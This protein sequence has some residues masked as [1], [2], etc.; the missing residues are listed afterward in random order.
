[1]QHSNA[2]R[3]R[4]FPRLPAIELGDTGALVEERLPVL[5]R[6]AVSAWPQQRRQSPPCGAFS[7]S[8]TAGRRGARAS[9]SRSSPSMSSSMPLRLPPV[10]GPRPRSH[11]APSSPAVQFF[12]SQIGAFVLRPHRPQPGLGSQRASAGPVITPELLSAGLSSDDVR[13]L[14]AAGGIGGHRGHRSQQAAV[15]RSY[16]PYGPDAFALA[17]R[18]RVRMSPPPSVRGGL[19]ASGRNPQ[20]SCQQASQASKPRTAVRDSADQRPASR[21]H[22]ACWRQRDCRRA[23]PTKC[24]RVLRPLAGDRRAALASLTRS[25]GSQQPRVSSGS[26]TQRDHCSKE[27]SGSPVLRS[28][29]TTAPAPDRQRRR[30]QLHP[31]VP[32][33][34]ADVGG[35]RPRLRVFSARIEVHRDEPPSKVFRDRQAIAGEDYEGRGVQGQHLRPAKHPNA[36]RP[37]GDRARKQV[38]PEGGVVQIVEK[39]G[40]AA[41]D[42]LRDDALLQLFRRRRPP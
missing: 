29:A 24:G 35:E 17:C 3:F 13:L 23:F 19:T 11:A 34:I 32:D 12:P 16:A 40:R 14:H 20:A 26:R 30:Q 28:E 6:P 31:P 37:F 25:T 18:F 10:A 41:L 42:Q 38:G 15:P 22:A 33:L 2:M 9:S 39:Q 1:M 7:G 8:S 4:L 27:P 5:D 36:R 21:R